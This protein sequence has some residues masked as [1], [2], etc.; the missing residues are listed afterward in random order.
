MLC[1]IRKA[2]K[3]APVT[4]DTLCEQ[5]KLT[6]ASLSQ[7]Q[8]L[9]LSGTDVLRDKPDLVDAFDTTL[10]SCLVLSTSLDM[11]TL[12]IKKGALRGDKMTW[13]MKFTTL[14]DEVE[15]KE[16][17]QHLHTQQGGISVLVDLL[18]V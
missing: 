5:L 17:L 2:W 12:K 4:V 15:I 1:E 14:W 8:S 3:H 13:K 10:T 9:L 16:L 6:A 18:Q 7:I 11:Y